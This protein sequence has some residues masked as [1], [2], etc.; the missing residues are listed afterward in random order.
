L[1]KIHIIDNRNLHI[2][3]LNIPYPPDYGGAID[4]YYKIK[5]LS[6]LGVG[7]ILHCFQYGRSRSEK[8]ESLCKE[9]HYYDR[10]LGVKYFLSS[11]PYIINTRSHKSLLKKLLDDP[12]P[13]LF[14]GI[15]TT[16]VVTYPDLQEKTMILRAHNIEHE[17]YR[18]LY[19][20]EK[21]LSKKIFFL[22]ESLKLARYEKNLP[23][24]LIIA[25]ISSSDA[26]YFRQV[27]R[28]VVHLPPFHPYEKLNCQP[29]LGDYI[30]FHG[31]L[32]VPENVASAVYLINNIFTKL[33]FKVVIAGKNPEPALLKHIRPYP[34]I[35]LVADP[36]EN[37]MNEL[38]MNAQ[39]NLLHTF[40]SSGIKLRLISVLFNGRHCLVN[41]EMIYG[42]GLDDVCYIAKSPAQTLT[43][44]E[45]LMNLPLGID[46]LDQ[47]RTILSE[48]F[49][50]IKNARIILDIL[51]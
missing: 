20:L 25:A 9:V 5:A 7:I 23:K 17:Y 22:T 30:L 28:K 31:N 26:D 37:E 1:L 48:N 4:I 3:S 24:K 41:P 21:Q 33:P 43:L 39:V 44:I 27:F 12:Y 8:L 11:V 49:S 40:Q 51:K 42:S 34:K 10:Y 32:S 13:V 38:I 29:G 35:R 14:E 46:E 47:R 16:S 6:N 50:N 2:V 18:G 36:S 45:R 15:H 19:K